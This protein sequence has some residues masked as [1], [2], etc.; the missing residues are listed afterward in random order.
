MKPQL[1]AGLPDSK[2]FNNID[3]KL[4]FDA[5]QNIKGLEEVNYK[6]NWAGELHL[7]FGASLAWIYERVRKFQWPTDQ[8]PNYKYYDKIGVSPM[9]VV[10][11]ELP[12][13]LPGLDESYVT[14]LLSAAFLYDEAY[15]MEKMPI[16]R[17]LCL[18]RKFVT[19]E[20]Y[21][22]IAR[23]VKEVSRNIIFN[24]AE[25]YDSY[26]MH[27]AFSTPLDLNATDY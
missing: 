7:S 27:D 26:A 14:M 18:R 20:S 22:A 9:A 10:D 15:N 24:T 11:V 16:F 23:N 1:R 6:E 17:D 12:P 4:F 19:R 21:C 3:N 13:H 5:V 25:R 2:L 8:A